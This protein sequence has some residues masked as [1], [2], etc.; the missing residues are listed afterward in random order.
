LRVTRP[1]R[2]FDGWLKALKPKTRK[3]RLAERDAQPPS[4]AS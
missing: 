4:P 3:A 2:R 1:Q